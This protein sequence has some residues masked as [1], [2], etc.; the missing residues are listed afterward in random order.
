MGRTKNR[1]GNRKPDALDSFKYWWEDLEHKNQE[2]KESNTAPMG[3][4]KILDNSNDN[5]PNNTSGPVVQRGKRFSVVAVPLARLKRFFVKAI[6][7][8]KVFVYNVY[9]QIVK[10]KD[11]IMAKDNSTTSDKQS[12]SRKKAERKELSSFLSGIITIGIALAWV[13]S[14]YCVILVNTGTGEDM[15]PKYASAPLGLVLVGTFL[16]AIYKTIK[17]NNR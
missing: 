6:D 15:F 12:K 8:S 5:R 11:N 16:V 17:N 13:S 10:R 3:K 2:N 14:A 7:T 1:S 9:C 4:Q